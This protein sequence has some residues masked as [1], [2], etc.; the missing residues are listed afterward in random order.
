[1]RPDLDEGIVALGGDELDRRL[2]EH[3]QPDVPPPQV[4]IELLA[5]AQALDLR[6]PLT[7]SVTLEE[8]SRRLRVDVP[9][10]EKDRYA[11]PDIEAAR[12][13]VVSGLD[14]LLAPL[15]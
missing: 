6:R 8:V 10:W 2:E 5:A 13:L 15:E 12:S 1:M 4:G 9:T 3:R 14:D 11:A 7:S